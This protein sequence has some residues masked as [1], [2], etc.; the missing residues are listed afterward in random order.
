[1]PDNILSIGA[2]S[3]VPPSPAPGPFRLRGAWDPAVAYVPNDVVTYSNGVYGAKTGNINVVPVDGP[4]WQVFVVDAF[5]FVPLSGAVP[6]QWV[7]YVDFSGGQHLSQPAFSDIS[8][9]LTAGQEPSTTVNS[10][11]ND[12]NVTGSIAA[13]AL[14][15]GWTGTLAKGRTLATTVYTD[16]ANTFGA[17]LQKFQAGANFDLADP[18][19]TTKIAQF[20]LSN[21]A[22]GTT[23]TINVPNANSTTV[24]S[25]SAAAHQFATGISAQGVVAYGQP[26]FTDISGT[27]L[28]G[29]LPADTAYVD[30]IQTWSAAQTFN[31]GKLVFA[32]STSGTTTVNASA[33]ASG[34]LTLPAATDTL[35][36]K[37]TTD[38]FT[39]KSFDTAGAGNSFKINGTAVTAVT[40]TGAAV[41]ATSPSLVT[42]TI[43]SAGAAF[44]GSTSGATTVAASA[45]A[46]G[47]L[48]LPA[49]TDTLVGKAT[50]D[51]LT[52]KT[53][54]SATNTIEFGGQPV[55]VATLSTNQLLQYN[56]TNWVN[57]TVSASS[58][59]FSGI[60]TATNTAA[61]MT[62]GTG[63]SLTTSGTGT[64]SATTAASSAAL[65]ISGQTGLLTFTGLATTNRAK[66]VRDAADTILEL[67]GSYTP[68]GTWTNMTFVTPTLGAASA[69][70]INKVAITAPATSATL[71]IANGK[72]LTAN[73]SLTLAGTD[74]TTLTFQGT[75]TYV[76]RATTDTLTSKTL[77]GSGLT[78]KDTLFNRFRATQ[79][80]ALTTADVGS[81]TGWGSTASVSSV[82]GTDAA[83]VVAISSSGTGV[84]ANPTFTVTFKDGTWTNPP[85]VQI[86]RAEGNGPAAPPFIFGVSATQLTVGGLLASTPAAGVTYVF[87]VT[88][89]GK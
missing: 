68:T 59:A 64:I 49:A 5:V 73:N 47:T 58:V 82:T 52:N 39:N 61:T 42:P 67:G 36:G 43:G 31:S 35:V 72:T 14:T 50:T 27:L 20:G 60:T 34:T 79:G 30:V 32:G 70:S 2:V 29:Q 55:S 74:S 54:D 28:A 24:Q 80:T 26:A 51:I 76:G 45:T 9:T 83:F 41:L 7:Q 65:S 17:A 4:V 88:C 8:G 25:S 18:T 78:N 66:T 21:I 85:I 12:T 38:V 44:S 46:S 81:L 37:A 89:T 11:V 13:Q 86:T 57:A 56:G 53:L 3:T 48:T 16:Q 87:H 1:M 69:T 71:T 62:V 63:A 19:D 15:L 75:D 33:T 10:V 77:G 23:R 22:T 84:A 40:G 6:H